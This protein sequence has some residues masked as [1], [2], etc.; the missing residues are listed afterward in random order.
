MRAFDIVQ[1]VGTIVTIGLAVIIWGLPIAPGILIY[2]EAISRTSTDAPVIRAVV[3]GLAISTG[4]LL[5]GI[6]LLLISGILQ[7]ILHPRIE[8]EKV[9]PLAS[10]MTIR[11]ALTGLLHRLTSPMLRHLVPSFIANWYYRLCGCKL[12]IGAQ[13][14]SSVVNDAYAVKIGPETVVGGEAIINCHLVED[15]KLVLAPVT[16]GARTTIGGGASI[17]PGSKIGDDVIVAYHAVVIKRT[18]IPDG[19]VWGGL[20]A[21]KIR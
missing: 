3:I 11:W 13:V 17:L 2:D 7:F 1:V 10:A 4:V 20:P 9:Y 6:C 5:W 8:E 14:N 15:G 12:G 19:E 21:K 18:V 16:I